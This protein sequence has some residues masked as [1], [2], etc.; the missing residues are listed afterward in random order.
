MGRSQPAYIYGK[1][2][3]NAVAIDDVPV[4]RQRK[5]EVRNSGPRVPNSLDE[6]RDP[7]Q[8]WDWDKISGYVV[9]D[10]V[11]GDGYTRCSDVMGQTV[12]PGEGNYDPPYPMRVT[13]KGCIMEG[14]IPE[15][16]SGDI[17]KEQYGANRIRTG[18]NGNR[19]AQWVLPFEGGS[20][21][22]Y[23]VEYM[24]LVARDRVPSP[25][26]DSPPKDE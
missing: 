9:P 22:H 6:E 7:S 2:N 25:I 14:N 20:P 5:E 18:D 24:A 16:A 17:A 19:Y 4:I 26:P 11:P 1:R 12:K 3:P 10:G 15:W 21:R 13:P 8:R 23:S